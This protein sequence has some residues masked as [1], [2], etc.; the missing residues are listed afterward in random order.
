MKVF[1]VESGR[2]GE[3]GRIH[4]VFLNKDDAAE[5]QQARIEADISISWGLKRTA[6]LIERYARGKM[7]EKNRAVK[8]CWV[9]ALPIIERLPQPSEEIFDD[10]CLLREFEVTE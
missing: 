5:G 1:I 10:W 7:R 8:V 2:A 6:M 4:G 3:G 9:T